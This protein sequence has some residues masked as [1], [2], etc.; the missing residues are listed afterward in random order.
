MIV[1]F[2]LKAWKPINMLFK[3]FF[4]WKLKVKNRLIKLIKR[5]YVLKDLY[6]KYTKFAYTTFSE[7]KFKKFPYI[8]YYLWKSQKFRIVWCLQSILVW[9]WK[10]YKILLH[11]NYF[12]LVPLILYLAFIKTILARTQNMNK[13]LN[14][15]KNIS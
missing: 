8:M 11:W 5:K 7:K 6:I 4:F 13:E 10:P 9:F 15:F 1:I 14:Q 2:N 12:R 3:Y